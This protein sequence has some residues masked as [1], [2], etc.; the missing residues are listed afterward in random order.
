MKLTQRNYRTATANRVITFTSYK[1]ADYD[2]DTRSP[3]K[4]ATPVEVIKANN[5][6]KYTNEML[7]R[8]YNPLLYF[9]VKS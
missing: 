1:L 7:R 8:G 2:T 9:Y 3:K 5:G 6:Q 4:G